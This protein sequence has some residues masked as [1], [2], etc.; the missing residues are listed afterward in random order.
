MEI[1]VDTLSQDE[2]DEL[3][4]DSDN[5][6]QPSPAAETEPSPQHPDVE[7]TKAFSKRLKERTD[8]AIAEER[9][10]IATRLGYKSYDDMIKQQEN[11]KLEDLGYDPEQ[12]GPIV[13]ELVQKRIN[14]DPR[15]KELETFREKQV[16]EF[17][18]KELTEVSKLTGINYTSLE[19]LPQDVIEDWRKTGSLKQ[20]YIKLHGE[21]L[22]LKNKAA[23]SRGVTSHLEPVG[24]GGVA[25]ATE[26][27][28]R[29]LT[30]EEKK[31]WKFFNPQMTDEEL[32]K[33]LVDR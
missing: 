32:D 13:E 26:T 28:K 17:A 4:S 27:H 33:K 1:G 15:M 23:A 25:P 30:A 2:L 21:E 7:N 31:V 6:K 8:K 18:I 3:F 22:I 11:R 16:Q 19:Q 24:T 10:S 5:G 29:H 20:S 9:E 12:L 14:S